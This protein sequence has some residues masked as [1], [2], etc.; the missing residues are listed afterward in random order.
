M[1]MHISVITVNFNNKE[2][3]AK[4]V[5]SVTA[6]DVRPYEFIV[7]DGG[8]SDGSKEFLQ[9]YNDVITYWVSEPDSGIYNAM[10]KGIDRATGDW[11]IFMNSG[12]SFCDGQVLKHLE[13]SGAN[14][15]IICGNTILM[16]DTSEKKSALQKISLDVLYD[17]VICH[18]S[19]FIRTSILK[20]Y[21]Y[22]EHYKLDADRKLFVQALI[23]DNVSYQ[24]IDLDVANYD[25]TGLSS[26][27]KMLCDQEYRLVLSELIPPRI[28]SDYGE[29]RDGPLFGPTPYDRLFIEI[30]KRPWKKPVECLVRLFL[31]AVSPFRKSARFERLI[32]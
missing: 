23:L 3:L 19:A 29:R 12:D 10:N 14:A 16:Y 5:Q 8:S 32:R 9:A 21:H 4:T 6:Q 13:E 15:D 30:G 18:Q 31:R 2:G 27:N 11:C 7:I 26:W 25:M 22:D 20:K 17:N 1:R 24:G 28:L